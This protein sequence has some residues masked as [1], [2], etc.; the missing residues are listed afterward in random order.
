MAAASRDSFH[1]AV[2]DWF[3]DEFCRAKD[4][5]SQREFIKRTWGLYKLTNAADIDVC[6]NYLIA[7]NWD[8]DFVIDLRD[9]IER[10]VADY[11]DDVL[12]NMEE[13]YML[14]K[15]YCRFDDM[16]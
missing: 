9:D 13:D 5:G 12:Y 8:R 10:W 11:A 2:S 7:N 16:F 6:C 14:P 3:Y 1:E 15:E 4:C